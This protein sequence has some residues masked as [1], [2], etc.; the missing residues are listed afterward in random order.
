M[1]IS[2]WSSDVCS[3]DLGESTQDFVAGKVAGTVVRRLEIIEV[4]KHEQ[5]R[6][7]CM[8]R[9]L[10][11]LRAAAVKNLLI[12]RAGHAVA[13]RVEQFA[14]IGSP[15]T[16]DSGGDEQVGGDGDRDAQRQQRGRRSEEQTSERQALMR[17]S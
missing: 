12:E 15:E 5:E 8:P 4:E 17:N 3:S 11:R 2:D 9:I 7:A 16:G 10:D 6:S 1:R 13:V 14:V